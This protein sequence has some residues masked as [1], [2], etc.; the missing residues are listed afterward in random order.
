MNVQMVI[1]FRY[2][3]KKA[4]RDLQ[5]NRNFGSRY[6]TE[7]IVECILSQIR[8][9][10]RSIQPGSAFYACSYIKVGVLRCI[11]STEKEVGINR[12]AYRVSERARTWAIPDDVRKNKQKKMSCIKTT[13][14]EQQTDGAGRGRV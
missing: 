9:R 8:K 3:V 4:G 13:H 5:E 10:N 11:R 14:G 1:F 2:R 12:G 6:N 7:D